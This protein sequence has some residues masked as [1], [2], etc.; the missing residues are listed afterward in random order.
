ML[1]FELELFCKPKLQN[2]TTSKLRQYSLHYSKPFLY[3]PYHREWWCRQRCHSSTFRLQA[4][5]SCAVLRWDR[6]SIRRRCRLTFYCSW[7][8]MLIFF[9]DRSQNSNVV[10]LFSMLKKD[11][12]HEQLVY[13]QVRFLVVSGLSR[14][15]HSDSNCYC[16]CVD[17]R[18]A[19]ERILFPKLP[20]LSWPISQ[21]LLMR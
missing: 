2:I 18:R 11:T 19:S 5:N 8:G 7:S 9:V 15:S 16:C 10:L 4:A 21:R 20:R 14:L 12:P 17:H 6:R 13:Y 3:L 1:N